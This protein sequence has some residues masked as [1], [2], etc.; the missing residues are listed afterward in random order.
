MRDRLWK[1]WI[2][3]GGIL[4]VW[5]S[6]QLKGIAAEEKQVE[7]LMIH[8]NPCESCNEEGRL[9]DLLR[10]SIPAEYTAEDFVG[11]V[12]YL[13]RQDG[14]AKAE[15]TAS[16]FGL[17]KSE[18]FFP[19]V[20][21]GDQYL[22]GSDVVQEKLTELLRNAKEQ[23]STAVMMQETI[24]DEKR[25]PVPDAVEADNGNMVWDVGED[26][27]HLLYFHTINC[28]DCEK[29]EEVL[30]E[31]PETVILNG[32]EYPV[33]ITTVSVMDGNNA[34]ALEVI[35]ENRKIPDSNRKVPCLL[36]GEEWLVGEKQIRA[37][38]LELTETGNGLGAVYRA[39]P[40]QTGGNTSPEADDTESE[41]LLRTIGT[42]F[43]NGF[44]PC[45]LSLV[46]L[47]LSLLSGLKRGFLRFGF[48]F[49]AGKLLAYAMIGT[50]AVMAFQAIPLAFFEK[51]RQV[52]T[53]ILVVGCLLM[54]F[55]NFRDCYFALRGQYGRIRMQLPGKLRR[56]NDSMMKKIVD[57]RIGKW[58]I[59][60]VFL[61]SMLIACGEFFCT[62]QIYLAYLLQQ[63]QTSGADGVPLAMLWVY[64]VA[65]CVPS[66]C[67]ILLVHRGK[68]VLQLG[69]TSLKGM[70]MIKFCNGF[71]FL[72]FVLLTLR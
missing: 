61:G 32:R 16:R 26:R 52:L 38:A 3:I 46:L 34:K 69:Q 49:L 22:M 19:L 29:A 45:A 10:E 68:S 60:L 30:G 51:V 31:L 37:R 2:L 40:E 43:L 4:L 39:E 71:L 65:L 55:G 20:V 1:G 59:L 11:K 41:L 7:V 70:P 24:D 66:L 5:I 63:I 12:Y 21:A 28:E 64:S 62:G 23:G 17:E 54:A 14:D 33:M 6:F 18:L 9:Y 8:N 72:L 57:P 13:Y 56:W 67:L 35:A 53:W 36:I 15:Q 58:L 50:A 42:G 27:I 44:N 25:Q 47:F 48:S